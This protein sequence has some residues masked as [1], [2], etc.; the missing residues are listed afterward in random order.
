MNRQAI[1]MNML[2]KV[3]D[4]QDKSIYFVFYRYGGNGDFDICIKSERTMVSKLIYK[5]HKSILQK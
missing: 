2:C 1:E 4:S 3:A 5:I